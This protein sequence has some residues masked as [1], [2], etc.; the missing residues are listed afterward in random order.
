VLS[1]LFPECQEAP[2]AKQKSSATLA[3]AMLSFSVALWFRIRSAGPGRMNPRAVYGGK[4]EKSFYNL[5]VDLF[6]MAC[7]LKAGL[8]VSEC[9]H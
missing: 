7:S 5:K 4:I 8:T 3:C 1:E 6:L 9:A 2:F